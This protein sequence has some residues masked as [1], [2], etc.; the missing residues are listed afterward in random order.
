MMDAN[1]ITAI[2][3]VLLVAVAGFAGCTGSTDNQDPATGTDKPLYIVGVDGNYKPYSYLDTDG[4]PT[5]FDVESIKWIADEMGFE[6]RIQPMQWDGIIPSLVNKKID[7]V[8]SGM[9]ISPERLEKVNF[10]E[11]YWVIDQGVAVR[12]DSELTME[13]ITSGKVA[14]GVQRG[15][16]ANTW[17][18]TNLIEKGILPKEKLS[19]YDNFPLAITDLTNKRI[20]AAMYDLPVVKKAIEDKPVKMLGTL[21]T[22]EEYGIAVR[23]GD[24]ELRNTLN[25]GLDKLM[26]SPKWQELIEK[27]SMEE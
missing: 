13:D 26:N 6:V 19:L 8:Y 27:Y 9:T 25:E 23:K 5:G 3:A 11:P 18:Q 14:I 17:I 1:V 16:T 22:R 2:L 20:E 4:N 12:E 24:T 21:E 7:M 15:C 10:T